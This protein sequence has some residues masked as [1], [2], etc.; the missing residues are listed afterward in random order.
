MLMLINQSTMLE[1]PAGQRVK[2]L[3]AE[4]STWMQ[5]ESKQHMQLKTITKEYKLFKVGPTQ[6]SEIT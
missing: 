3:R 4:S 6:V 1:Q 5:A 2:Q